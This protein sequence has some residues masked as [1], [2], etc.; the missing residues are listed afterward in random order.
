[1]LGARRN[2]PLRFTED[3][4]KRLHRVSVAR[5]VSVQGFAHAAVMSAIADAEAE[6]HA[7]VEIAEKLRSKSKKT[8]K[9]QEVVGLGTNTAFTAQN[10]QEPTSTRASDLIDP[11][12]EVLL[13]VDGPKNAQVSALAAYVVKGP[14]WNREQ[15]LVEAVEAI[16]KSTSDKYEQRGLAAGLDEAIADM[17]KTTSDSSGI[18]SILNKVKGLIAE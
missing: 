6:L 14:K 11:P 17:E 18:M 2:Q 8:E 16:K 9:K 5:G 12:S 7:E 4:I 10:T 1:M 3:Q 15:R 13:P